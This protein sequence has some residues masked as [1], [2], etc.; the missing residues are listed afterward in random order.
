[1]EVRLS[2]LA[3]RQGGGRGDGACDVYP[4]GLLTVVRDRCCSAGGVRDDGVGVGKSSGCGCAGSLTLLWFFEGGG[5]SL[6]VSVAGLSLR[7]VGPVC[8]WYH[9]QMVANL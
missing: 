8:A 3:D 9:S 1:M 4:P 7:L 2:R 6:G 5:E